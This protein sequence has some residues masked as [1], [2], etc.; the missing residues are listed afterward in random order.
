LKI[1]SLL[2]TIYCVYITIIFKILTQYIVVRASKHAE[3][4]GFD[5]K[6]D[7]NILWSVFLPSPSPTATAP[8][9]GELS[10]ELTERVNQCIS[11]LGIYI[12]AIS[13]IFLLSSSERALIPSPTRSPESTKFWSTY[14][15]QPFIHCPILCISSSVCRG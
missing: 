6:T 1:F 12:F 13:S 2:T 14:L 7:H 15:W 4:H 5:K 11:A 3:T 8:P 10:A 9:L